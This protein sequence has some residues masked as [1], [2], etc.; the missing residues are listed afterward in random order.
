MQTDFEVTGS[1]YFT[2]SIHLVHFGH[3]QN[4]RLF[5]FKNRC[6]VFSVGKNR[7]TEAKSTFFGK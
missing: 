4:L 3:F 7:P 5:P 2:R 1:T 6:I